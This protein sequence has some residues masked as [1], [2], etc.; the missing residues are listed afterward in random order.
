[1]GIGAALVMPATLSIITTIFP[2]EERDAC[3]RGLGRLRGRRRRDRADRVRR[4][5]RDVLVGSAV[6]VNLPL[7][8]M[9]FVAIWIVRTRVT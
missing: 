3:D 2:P 7:V 9:T 4:V 1:M 6:L 8:A 5:A